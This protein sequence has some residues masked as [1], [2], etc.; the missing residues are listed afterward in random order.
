MT[1][2]QFKEI[3]KLINSI[4]S[5]TGDC[6]YIGSVDTNTQKAS[7]FLESIDKKLGALIELLKEMN[8]RLP[9]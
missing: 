8:S 3:K 1:E 7:E 2:D 6:S 4:D 5:N 9:K